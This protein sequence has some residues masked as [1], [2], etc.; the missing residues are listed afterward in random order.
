MTQFLLD[1]SRKH[2]VEEATD[3]FKDS[4]AFTTDGDINLP[5]GLHAPMFRDGESSSAIQSV[6]MTSNKKSKYVQFGFSIE[7]Q[8]K[9][10]QTP[11]QKPSQKPPQKS[12]Q[13]PQQVQKQALNQVA[14]RPADKKAKVVPNTALHEACS[15]CM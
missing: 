14:T 15:N 13:N 3:E 5:A 9:P 6:S 11:P 8:Q 4:L 1:N 10:T 7:S 2:F 12:P